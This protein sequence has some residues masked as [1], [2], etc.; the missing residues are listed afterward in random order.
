MRTG[1]K[2]ILKCRADFAYGAAGSPPKIPPNATLL[3]EVELLSWTREEDISTLKDGTLMKRT[4]V[5]GIDYANPEFEAELCADVIIH[6]GA[7]APEDASERTALWERKAW[8]FVLGETPLPPLLEECLKKMRKTE[9]AIFRV[10]AMLVQKAF[11]EFNIPSAEERQNADISYEIKIHELTTITTWGL[12]SQEKITQGNL[13]VDK[14]NAAFKEGDLTLAER[15]YRRAME[16]LGEYFPPED[17]GEVEW[18]KARVRAMNNL[19]QV[20]LNASNFNEVLDLCNKIL[21]INPSEK[22]ALFRMAKSLNIRQEWDKA[23]VALD[24]ILYE[25]PNNAD[26]KALR[27]QVST[28]KRSYNQKQRSMFKKMFN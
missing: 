4:L 27:M 25:D 2:A 12:P 24:K 26:A 7:Y 17:E 10:A 16:F 5:E 14:G 3:F 23:L 11:P 6:L 19:S 21:Q 8:T 13:R 1:E 18:N 22:K 28:E 20:L 9:S 15:F